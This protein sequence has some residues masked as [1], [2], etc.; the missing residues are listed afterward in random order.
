MDVLTEDTAAT[1]VTHI[2]AT[3]KKV[4]HL[5]TEDT[6]VSPVRDIN[7]TVK[8][9]SHLLTAETTVSPVRDINATVKKVSHVIRE[10]I[11]SLC[12]D[13]AGTPIVH[14]HRKAC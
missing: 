13:G 9:V 8:K 4:N 5:L 6:T 7:A 10:L 14:I 1:P 3:V 12:R 2:N 11:D